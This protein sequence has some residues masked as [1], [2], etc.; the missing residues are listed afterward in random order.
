RSVR[1]FAMSLAA[2]RSPHETC[3]VA[4]AA[5]DLPVPGGDPLSR[6]FLDPAELPSALIGKPFPEFGLTSLDDTER[7]LTRADLLGKPALVNV[8]ATWCPSCRAEHPVLNKL[9]QSGVNIHG[10]NYKD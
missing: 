3:I 8:W 9:A 10:I 4:G 2:R 6:T 5:G 1:A 7:T